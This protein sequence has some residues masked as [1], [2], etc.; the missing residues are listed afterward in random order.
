MADAIDYFSD[1][2]DPPRSIQLNNRLWKGDIFSHLDLLRE[3]DDDLNHWRIASLRKSLR[4]VKALLPPQYHGSLV[5]RIV[6]S[7]LY[8]VSFEPIRF[9]IRLSDAFVRANS[10]VGPKNEVYLSAQHTEELRHIVGLA[11]RAYQDYYGNDLVFSHFEVRYMN[12]THDRVRDFT[13]YGAFSDFHLDQ[14]M[15]FTCIIYLCA[16]ARD[17]GCFS[18]ISGTNRIRKSHLLRALHQVVTFDMALPRPEQTS[19]LPLELRGGMTYGNF[20]DDDKVERL[21]DARVDFV[22]NVGDGIMFD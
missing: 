16:V 8:Q 10:Y 21:R 3:A 1:P 2:L 14:Q 9:S 20:L 7:M 11:Q 6:Y 5:R 15:S 4:G 22:G 12:S 18:Y 19:H 17:N 13:T